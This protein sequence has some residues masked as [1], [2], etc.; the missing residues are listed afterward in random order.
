MDIEIWFVALATIGL[1]AL[2][3]IV[4]LALRKKDIG[5]GLIAL[6]AILLFITP[7]AGGVGILYWY[8]HHIPEETQATI[9]G[10]VLAIGLVALGLFNNYYG[11]YRIKAG[12]TVLGRAGNV[13]LSQ[14][15][16]IFLVL[17]C[18]LTMASDLFYGTD[19]KES[20]RQN[21]VWWVLA[22][23]LAIHVFFSF[24]F[25]EKGFVYRGK[26]ILFSAIEHAEW[27]NPR[28]KT[29]LKIKLTNKEREIVIK[30]PWELNV[31]IDNYLRAN[32]PNP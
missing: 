32:F 27:E 20:I 26:V 18:L 12:Y 7:W 9:G 23:P 1:I 2:L 29:K 14:N 16:L 10:I 11:L 17:Y 22:I 25:R 30:T 13:R 6:F 15:V 21:T 31:Q 19:I 4:T 8:S 24:E 3:V 28:D 5:L